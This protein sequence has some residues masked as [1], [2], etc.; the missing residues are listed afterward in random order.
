MHC[1]QDK[2]ILLQ[3]LSEKKDA[4]SLH[5][6]TESEL[7]DLQRELEKTLGKVALWTAL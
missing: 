7:E 4:P 1:S 3:Y 6:E 2:L 5:P